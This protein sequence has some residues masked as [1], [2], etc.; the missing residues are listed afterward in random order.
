M[1][2]PG[3]LCLKPSV[4]PLSQVRLAVILIKCNKMRNK[5]TFDHLIYHLAIS[6]R[7]NQKGENFFE[8]SIRV[9]ILSL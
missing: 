6:L 4:Q 3:L 5:D 8:V 7:G 2:D 1:L 9:K